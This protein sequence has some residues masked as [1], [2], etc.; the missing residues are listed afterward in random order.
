[1]VL[2]V[3]YCSLLWEL[4]DKKHRGD[5][6]SDLKSQLLPQSNKELLKPKRQEGKPIYEKTKA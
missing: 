5:L 6:I 2:V 4:K 3:T 1:M